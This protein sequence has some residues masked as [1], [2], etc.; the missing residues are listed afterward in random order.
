MCCEKEYCPAY[1]K[2]C[3]KCKQ[4]NH[5]AHGYNQQHKPSKQK[6]LR[7]VDESPQD[8]PSSSETESI[9]VIEETHT[10]SAK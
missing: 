9:C 5:F 2:E 1:G 4:K 3:N 7:K 6:N 10:L 8:I